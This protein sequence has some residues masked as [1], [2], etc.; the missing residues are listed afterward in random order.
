MSGSDGVGGAVKLFWR[1]TSLHISCPLLLLLMPF[2]EGTSFHGT[3]TFPDFYSDMFLP[4]CMLG[5]YF[6]FLGKSFGR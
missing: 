3:S 6:V 2:W 5:V 1:S 4:F